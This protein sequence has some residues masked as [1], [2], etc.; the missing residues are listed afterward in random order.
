[1]P[2]LGP[3]LSRLT[4]SLQVEDD[5]TRRALGWSPSVA[6]EAGL[7]LTARAYARGR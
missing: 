5:E 1:L 7:A 3:P 2:G 6:V 4:L